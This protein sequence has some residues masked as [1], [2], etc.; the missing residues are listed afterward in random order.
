MVPRLGGIAMASAVAILMSGCD[1]A[2]PGS[3]PQSV[4]TGG[5]PDSRLTYREGGVELSKTASD[6]L[7]DFVAAI[8]FDA[9]LPMSI[10]LQAMNPNARDAL[11]KHVASTRQEIDEAVQQVRNAGSEPSEGDIRKLEAA[12]LKMNVLFKNILKDDE[13]GR[14]RDRGNRLIEK[15]PWLRELSPDQVRDVL[16]QAL[17]KSSKRPSDPNPWI[18]A[19]VL[20]DTGDGDT[21]RMDCSITAAVEFGAIQIVYGSGLWGCSFTTVAFL[22]C[23]GIATGIQWYGIGS[24][25]WDLYTC[26]KKCN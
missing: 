12:N 22:P 14:T 11:I 21:C 1:A 23:F 13:H 24:L 25:V 20:G 19:A 26:T 2:G 18:P 16:Y 5:S 9:V 3:N 17:R 6:E 10:R 7:A 8:Q 15:Y 4:E